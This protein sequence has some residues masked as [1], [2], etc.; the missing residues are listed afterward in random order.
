VSAGTLGTECSSKK[1][2]KS[3]DFDAGSAKS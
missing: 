1:G 2:I 3:I